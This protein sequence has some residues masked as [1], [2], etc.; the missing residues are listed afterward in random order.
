[1]ELQK[2]T[3]QSKTLKASTDI[4]I[5]VQAV[6]TLVGILGIQ[7][8]LPKHHEIL[9]KLLKIEVFVQIVEIAMYIYLLRGSDLHSMATNRYY[10]WIITTPVMLFTTVVYFEYEKRM[11]RGDLSEFSLRDFTKSNKTQIITIIGLNMLM[12]F[13]GYLG[14]TGKM[15]LYTSNA[16]G[17]FAFAVYFYIIY[18]DFAIYSRRGKQLFNIFITIWTTYGIVALFDDTRKN[19]TF[20]F[21]DIIAKNFFGLY[22]YYKIKDI[23]K[24]TT[25]NIAIKNSMN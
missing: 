9:I 10:D 16:L 5:V 14:E 1:M 17:F 25:T 20:N 15:D 23:K 24:T 3:E 19:I 11:E 13:Y 21:L 4:S 7:E 18:K 6:T 8:S 22:L 12:L 2:T